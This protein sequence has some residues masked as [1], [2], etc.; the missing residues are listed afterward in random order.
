MPSRSNSTTAKPAGATTSKRFEL[1]ALEFKFGSL[2][3]GTDIPPPAPS[4]VEEKAAPTPPETPKVD[5]K[6]EK[7]ANGKPDSA[8]SPKSH[9]SSI[10]TSGTKRRAEDNPASPTL[11]NRPGSIRRLF[12]RGL[13]N[14]AYANGDAAV[15]QD[16]RPESRGNSSVADSRKVKR[17]S[18]W[19]GR[20]RGNDGAVNKT[21]TPLSPPA[22][23][24]EKKPMGP[25]PP[26]IPEISELKS[27]IG[28][29]DESGFGGDLF[30]D[31]K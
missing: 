29:Q 17:S 10:T 2:T 1:P 9:V 21:T 26:M 25:P 13:L 31:I 16:G 4:P 11:S 24:D 14:N 23:T 19:F 8:L 28:V 5:E 3:D 30:K 15:T 7:A 6:Q 18:G 12:S 22:T 27:K 20:L